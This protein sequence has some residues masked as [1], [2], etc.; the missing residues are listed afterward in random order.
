MFEQI[1]M[2]IKQVADDR[3]VPRNVRT[4][5]EECVTILQNEKQELSIRIGTVITDLDEV[6]NDPN[7]PMY[8]RTM[9]WNIVSALE[10]LRQKQ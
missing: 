6:S 5:C 7:I 1:I 2:L 3:T 4:K 10:A 9:V 8:A